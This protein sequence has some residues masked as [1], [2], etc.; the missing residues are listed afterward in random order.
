M[1]KIGKAVVTV[2]LLSLLAGLFGCNKASKYTVDDIRSVSISCGHMVYSHSYSF[3][4]RKDE[5]K[6]LL[7]AE[8]ATDTEHPRVEYEECPVTEEDV[9]E[10]LNIVREQEVIEKLRH[11]KKPKIKVQVLDE[12]TYYTSILFAD[13]ERLDAA[14]LVSKDIEVYFYRLAEKYTDTISE[15]K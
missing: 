9:K 11:Y 2:A 6:W 12:T 8:F 4:L 15:N 7:D 14:T 13:K 5:N 1:R 10:L 3:Y